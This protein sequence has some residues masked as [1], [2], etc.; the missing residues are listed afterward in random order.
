LKTLGDRSQNAQNAP[1]AP[2]P[3]SC[4]T[5]ELSMRWLRRREVLWSISTCLEPVF[6]WCAS[7][8]Y[9]INIYIHTYI[10]DYMCMYINYIKYTKSPIHADLPWDYVL[11]IIYSYFEVKK[12]HQMSTKP[13]LITAVCT[14][15]LVMLNIFKYQTTIEKWPPPK[16]SSTLQENTYINHIFV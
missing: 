12:H 10:H 2:A 16:T 3:S 9:N 1:T 6:S 7:S 5:E 15:K 13:Q 4:Q 14:L 11:C 8:W